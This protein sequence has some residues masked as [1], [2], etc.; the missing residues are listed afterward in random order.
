M[1]RAVR[2]RRAAVAT[3]AW[4]LLGVDEK[5]WAR[6]QQYV[7]IVYDLERGT[8]IWTGPER[9]ADTLARF[10]ATL[11]AAQKAG[12]AG[13]TMDLWAGFRSA[14]V[15][16]LPDGASK[17]VF[18]RFHVMQ[19][20]NAA[21]DKVRR[22][23]NTRLLRA[24]DERLKGTRYVWL[25]AREALPAKYDA[26]LATLAATELDTVRAWR[27]KEA[28][29]K[30]WDASSARVAQRF[31]RWWD[32]AAR[33]SGLRA[34]V[35]A[36]Q[37]VADHLDGILAYFA[38]RI[39]NA[40]AEGINSGVQ[41]VKSRARGFRNVDHFQTAVLFYCGGDLPPTAQLN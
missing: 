18:D 13:V 37:S 1:E 17:V 38:H 23:E 8:A 34:M 35:Q 10:Y 19:R 30:L 4:R 12:I 15:A 32:R 2:P 5:A 25:Y 3:H 21:V 41:V 20:V 26:T 16:A 33:A 7:T 40:A 28:L 6:G 11:T 14:T 29:R 24:D 39:T 22:A 36:A 27:L 9:T 31:H